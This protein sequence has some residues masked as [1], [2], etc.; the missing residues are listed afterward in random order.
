GA[1]GSNSAGLAGAQPGGGGG[2]SWDSSAAQLGGAGGA[3][4]V[5]V[6]YTATLAPFQS[7]ILHR[8]GPASP[9][10]LTPFVST[11][12]A[13]D[14]PDGRQYAVPSLVAG[15]N[16]RF[17]GTYTMWLVAYN[18]DSPST[19]RT[20]TVTV[21]QYEYIGGPST[22]QSVSRTLIPDNDVVDNMTDI[23]VMTLPYRDMAP[24]NTT[25]Y[26][27]VGI[28]STDSSDRFLD[29]LM[30]DTQGQTLILA[31][32]STYVNFY[33]DAPASDVDIGRV[34]GSAFDR[35][36]AL[37]VMDAVLAASGGPMTIDPGDNLLLGY[38]V[39]G[40][41]ALAITYYPNFFLD[42]IS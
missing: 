6:T 1:S 3:G 15:Q 18:W 21:Y 10:S 17:N 30:L 42:R 16:A 32:P 9:Q 14:P 2:G 13:S 34:L 36:E 23:G 37:S 33:V 31:T 20:V 40:S 26:F 5:T 12:N 25:A 4:Q 35:N 8:P 38:C 28:N 29:V 19:S 41:P 11:T 24:D 22:S 39:E 27:T 7:L